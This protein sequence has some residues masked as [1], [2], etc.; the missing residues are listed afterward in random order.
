MKKLEILKKS[1][2]PDS[3]HVT[4]VGLHN[5]ITTLSHLRSPRPHP[6]Q[7]HHFYDNKTTKMTTC[8][9]QQSLKQNDDTSTSINMTHKQHNQNDNTPLAH[10]LFFV[11]PQHFHAT[12]GYGHTNNRM[13]IMTFLMCNSVSPQYFGVL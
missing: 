10:L 9:Q 6:P 2:P 13:V 4:V 7:Q 12:H 11:T 3:F 8:P 1:L 5:V